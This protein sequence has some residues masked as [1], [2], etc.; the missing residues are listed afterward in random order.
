MFLVNTKDLQIYC[1]DTPKT[2]ARMIMPEDPPALKTDKEDFPFK[3]DNKVR[4][5]VYYKKRLYTLNFEAGFKWDGTSI[6]SLFWMLIGSKEDNHFLL[7]SMVHDLLCNN[8]K[9]IDNNRYLSSLVLKELLLSCGVSKLKA[10]L[11]FVAV[12]NYQ[13]FQNW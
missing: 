11:M 2:R 5:N 12:D 13:R 10:N 6:P 4:I 9:L 3:L 8:K 7:A 1:S